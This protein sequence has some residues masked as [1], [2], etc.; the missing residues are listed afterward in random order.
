MDISDE[1]WS[2]C[3][4]ITYLAISTS[5]ALKSLSDQSVSH[6]TGEVKHS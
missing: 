6:Q 1:V 5:D 4:F 3:A 2:V